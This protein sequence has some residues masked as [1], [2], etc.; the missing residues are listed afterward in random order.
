M[1][2]EEDRWPGVS[3][4][5]LV[6][7]D[8]TPCGHTLIRQDS[9][10]LTVLHRY[11][12]ATEGVR[13]ARRN[14]ERVTESLSRV[15]SADQVPAATVEAMRLLLN[16]ADSLHYKLFA[17]KKALTEWAKVLN[18]IGFLDA[19]GQKHPLPENLAKLLPDG[20]SE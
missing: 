5:F 16:T 1:V 4:A 7:S 6:N 13:T 18:R 14:I 11:D 12:Q 10:D 15:T 19:F 3:G 20:E 9:P 17:E 8:G 2:L